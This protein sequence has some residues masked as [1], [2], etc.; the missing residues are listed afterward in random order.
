[1]IMDLAKNQDLLITSLNNG[2]KISQKSGDEGTS[3][4]II[5]RI[6]VHEKSKWM[7][8]SSLKN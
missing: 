7:L 8:I 5:Q 3:D 2:L 4:I 1:M 6:K